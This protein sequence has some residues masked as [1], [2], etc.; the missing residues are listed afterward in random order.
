VTIYD[1]EGVDF[2]QYAVEE[3]GDT[4]SAA[5]SAGGGQ[6]RPSGSAAGTAQP[7]R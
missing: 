2:F 3:Q 1:G 6:P 7:P 4:R 5:Q